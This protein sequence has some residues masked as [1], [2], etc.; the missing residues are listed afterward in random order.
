MSKALNKYSTVGLRVITALQLIELIQKQTGRIFAGFLP[1]WP[2]KLTGR[3]FTRPD[4][5]N[6]ETGRTGPDGKNLSGSNSGRYNCCKNQN[7][8]SNYFASE[9]TDAT[10]KSLLSSITMRK[11]DPKEVWKIPKGQVPICPQSRV[12]GILLEVLPSTKKM[13]DGISTCD[14]VHREIYW[15]VEYTENSSQNI[16]F[17]YRY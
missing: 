6:F 1:V 5:T 15:W 12:I 14:F 16:F 17:S 2:Q 3:I 8:L 4:R 11:V 10:D 13:N 9:G 7:I